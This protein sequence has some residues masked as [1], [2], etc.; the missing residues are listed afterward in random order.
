M[1]TRAAAFDELRCSVGCQQDTRLEQL[2]DYIQTTWIESTSWPP[3]AWSAFKETVRTNNDLEGT[4]TGNG[5]FRAQD[6]SFPR[7][8]SPYGEL[9]FPRLFVPWERKFPG[10]FVP[11]NFCSQDFSFLR[12]FYKAL[13]MNADSYSNCQNLFRRYARVVF[14][15]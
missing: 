3:T 8:N 13:T 2:A 4:C 11:R 15:C 9:S 1:G 14:F 7:T 12:L 5:T 6:L 10:H